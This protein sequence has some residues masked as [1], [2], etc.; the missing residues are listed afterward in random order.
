M[1]KPIVKTAVVLGL[2]A[3]LMTSIA[4]PSSAR[5]RWVG[6]AVGFAAGAIVGSAIANA[7]GCGYYGCPGPYYGPAYYGPAYYGPVYGAPGP[8]Y[9]DPNGG[10]RCWVTTDR[11]R[12]FGYYR[13]C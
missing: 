1:M 3:T 13:P 8:A 10:G 6:P 4:N 9:A 12:G 5:N 2:A 7:N 11:D